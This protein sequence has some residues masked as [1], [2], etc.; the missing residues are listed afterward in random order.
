M[1]II[2][3]LTLLV[4]VLALTFS[5]SACSS[6]SSDDTDDTIKIGVVGS[7]YDDL[8]APAITALAEEGINVELVQF[9]DFVTPNNALAN[10][11]I[12]LNAFQHRIYLESEISSHGYEIENI[13]NSFIIPLNIYSDKIESI[14]DLKA[15]DTVAIPDDL[16]NGGRALKILEDAGLIVLSAEAGFN[17][18]VADIVSYSVEI[19]IVELKANTLP[20]ALPDVTCAVINGNYALDFGLST[21]T[22]I[23]TDTVLDESAY[24]GL[25]AARSADLEDA[26]L[27][28]VY[29]KIVEAF[30]CNETLSVF[31]DDYDGY[32]IAV[33]WDEELI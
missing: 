25:I 8:W 31:N 30:Q 10:G 15:G 20:S 23:F 1:N 27:A 13:G 29:E 24:W 19:E 28:E 5:L 9:S 12:D 2:K 14:S 7:V 22:A 21:E 4:A 16:T 3:K 18:T 11:D 6:S 17:P 26:E 33:G 32:F